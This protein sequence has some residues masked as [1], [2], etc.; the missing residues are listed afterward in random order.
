M[1]GR[2]HHIPTDRLTALALVT[3]APQDHSPDNHDDTR[4]LE[5]IAHCDECA[6]RLAQ[7]TLDADGLREFAFAQA[8]QVFDEPMLDAQRTRILDRLAHLGQSA[9]V[10]SF[11]ARTREIAM[12]VSTNGRRWISVAAA[13]GLIIGLVT[14]QLIHF[15]PGTHLPLRDEVPSAQVTERARPA[16]VP[17][18]ASATPVLSDDELMAEVETAIESRRVRGLRVIDALT[19]T[20]ADLLASGR[21]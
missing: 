9:R 21:D 11:P 14:G 3:R 6:G 17:A 15:V 13:A 5:H 8:D 2:D 4:A 12:P 10:L 16:I 1:I 19:P 7:L 20:T 18:S